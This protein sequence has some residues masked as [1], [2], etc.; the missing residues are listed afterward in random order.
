MGVANRYTV[1][2]FKNTLGHN[3]KTNRPARGDDIDIKIIKRK[4][5]ESTANPNVLEDGDE[6]VAEGDGSWLSYVKIDDVIFWRIDD[7]LPQWKPKGEMNELILESDS[8][9]R[10]DLIAMKEN[11]WE[12][13]EDKKVELE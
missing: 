8:Q 10:I 6:I 5:K 3:H 1:G 11:K 2:W 13:A 12:E 4:N 9:N 7:P